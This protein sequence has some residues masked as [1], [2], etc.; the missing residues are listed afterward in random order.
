MTGRKV[1][2]D[3]DDPQ[4]L[5]KSDKSGGVAVHRPEALKRRQISQRSRRGSGNAQS[6]KRKAVGYALP[7][8]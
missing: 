1:R 4:Y 7:G 6:E 2:A 3:K 5:V 8:R